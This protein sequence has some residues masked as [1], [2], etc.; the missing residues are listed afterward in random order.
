MMIDS[1][2]NANLI[3]DLWLKYNDPNKVK[4]YALRDKGNKVVPFDESKGKGIVIEMVKYVTKVVKVDKNNKEINVNCRA[5]NVA[6]NALNG[7]RIYQ[8]FGNLRNISEPTEEE[9]SQELNALETDLTP[10]IYTWEMTDWYNK[11]TGE[12]L[13]NSVNKWKVFDNGKVIPKKLTQLQL[14]KLLL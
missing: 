14:D 8:S 3:L 13:T 2:S 9:I 12:S 10:G 5:L 11:E 7:L 1:E 4:N 6:Y